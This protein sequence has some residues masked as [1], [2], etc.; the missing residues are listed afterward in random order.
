MNL[1]SSEKRSLKLPFTWPLLATLVVAMLLIP[2]TVLLVRLHEGEAPELE[3]SGDFERMGAAANVEVRA[4]DQRSGLR[5]LELLLRQG[6]REISLMERD[7][8]RASWIFKAGAGEF[9][10][11]LNLDAAALKLNDGPALLVLR[12]RD[13]SWRDWLK[14]N[15]GEISASLVVDTRPPTL[16]V[17]SATRYLRAGGAGLVR[18]RVDEEVERH[19][20]VLNGFFHPGFPA[21]SGAPGEFLAYIALPFDTRS[22]DE[23]MVIAEDGAGNQGRSGVAVNLRRSSFPSDRINV[24]DNFLKG[25]LPEFSVH[26]PDMD[27][28]Y[29]EQYLYVNRK[30]RE[31]N[32]RKI[33]EI[34]R[35]SRP[36]RLWEGVFL[37]MSRSSKRAGYADRR[38]YF[39]G[40]E[41]VD[42]QVHLGVDLASVKHAEVEA[43]NHGVVVFADYLGIYGNTVIVDH[44]QGVF[45][46]YS[47]LS[48]IT[49]EQGTQV[50]QGAVLG[51]SGISG[52]AGGDHL[53]FSMLVNGIFVNPV[54]WWDEAWVVGQL[55]P[56][57]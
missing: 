52:M 11:T 51:H 14:G 26:Y 34:C 50:E 4:G 44:G 17:S 9:S 22:L 54:E 27:G 10:R 43:A 36:E 24:S 20:V 33:A 16:S 38:S 31:M 1:E 25:K 21:P 29:L 39:Y 53:H 13:Y 15:R 19:G 40:G 55:T 12:A 45:S 30:V 46:L 7:F 18:Y 48:R 57:S 8:P 56:E 32:N 49:V 5:R 41:K 42:E 37:R 2:A 23:A 47:H 35:N 3:L 28:S 6:E